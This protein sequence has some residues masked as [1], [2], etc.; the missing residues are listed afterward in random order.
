MAFINRSIVEKE[1]NRIQN[2]PTFQKAVDNIKAGKFV[3][4]P[5]R[6]RL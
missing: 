5:K 3:R 6:I 1:I 4:D 2:D